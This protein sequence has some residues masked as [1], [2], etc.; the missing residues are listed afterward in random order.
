ME[1]LD[2]VTQWA[3]R[4]PDWLAALTALVTGATAI[5]MITPTQMD[6]QILAKV[7]RFLNVFA[8]NFGMNKN[9]DDR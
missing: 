8:G 2:L 5:T 7:L 4:M 9:A 3:A 1:Y 6:N